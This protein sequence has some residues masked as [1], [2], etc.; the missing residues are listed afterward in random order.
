MTFEP[1]SAVVHFPRTAS[2]GSWAD[3]D[4][5]TTG[6]HHF[7]RFD[8]RDRIDPVKIQGQEGVLKSAVGEPGSPDWSKSTVLQIGQRWRKATDPG[9]LPGGELPNDG[10]LAT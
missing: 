7:A 9:R 5:T 6:G 3:V 2:T 4:L 1:E 10:C 8:L